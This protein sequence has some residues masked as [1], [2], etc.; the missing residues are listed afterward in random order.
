MKFNEA[1]GQFSHAMSFLA[2]ME[3]NGLKSQCG[4][5]D[6]AMDEAF[7]AWQWLNDSGHENCIFASMESIEAS[8]FWA[9]EEES[10][11]VHSQ[12]LQK[13]YSEMIE[14]GLKKEALAS[15]EDV[16]ALE[17]CFALPSGEG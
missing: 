4:N 12:N 1:A 8:S 15:P 9:V 17:A 11:E 3:F 5:W 2:A 6:K 14:A 16:A 7:A 10:I 13:L